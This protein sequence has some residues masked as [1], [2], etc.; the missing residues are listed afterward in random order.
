MEDVS[1]PNNVTINC[2]LLSEFNGS[3]HCE[4]QF[5]TDPTYMNLPYSAVS[6]ETGT[7]GDCVSVVLREQLNCSTVYY[8]TVS[9]ISEDVTVTVL[10]TFTI[11]QNCMYIQCVSTHYG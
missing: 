6:S 5:G 8:Y 1:S 11:P 9:A 7:A 10:G 2:I 3:A 4:V